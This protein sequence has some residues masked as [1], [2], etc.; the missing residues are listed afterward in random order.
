MGQTKLEQSWRGTAIEEVEDSTENYASFSTDRENIKTPGERWGDK[1]MGMHG[2]I[3][4]G[5]YWLTN[6]VG[7]RYWDGCV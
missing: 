3:A 4:G 6:K 1:N 2:L 5:S 7:W